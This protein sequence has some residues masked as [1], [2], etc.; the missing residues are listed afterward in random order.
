[1]AEIGFFLKKFIGAIL[2]PLPISL[3]IICLSLYLFK[4]RNHKI[5]R[6]IAIIGLSLL[7]IFSLPITSQYFIR[8]IEFAYPK[9]PLEDPSYLKTLKPD[10]IVVM[11]CWHSDDKK[12]PLVAKIHQCSL[13]RVV[14]AVQMW[15]QY[16]DA[17]LI[18]SGVGVDE[19]D[20]AKGK[21]SDPAIN[22]QLAMGLGVD[23]KQILLI[24]GTRDSEEEIAA[25]K[26]VVANSKFIVV[27]SAT[28][29][30]RLDLIYR[31]QGMYP[32]FSPAEYVSS[33]GEF[34][35]RLLLPSASALQQS[36]RA[37]YEYLGLAWVKV[38]SIF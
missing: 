34:S 26:K 1:M 10:Y 29:I 4:K 14:Q 21:V 7:V 5:A 28:H 13:P 17:T 38:K 6:R 31:H 23:K 22:A 2:M 30:S 37:I 33:H 35:W 20:I 15:H 24:E 27:S 32:I 12:L 11:G 19:S 3:F 9:L 25:Q 18:F 16:P 8:P 36:E